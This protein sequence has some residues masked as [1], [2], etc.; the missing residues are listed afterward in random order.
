MSTPI[1]IRDNISIRK[2]LETMTHVI[3]DGADRNYYFLPYWFTQE[4]GEDE[5]ELLRL[6][7]LPIPLRKLIMEMRGEAGE[8]VWKAVFEEWLLLDDKD[9]DESRDYLRGYE[10]GLNKAKQIIK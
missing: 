3:N 7:N 5:F 4:E 10:A 2:M 8:E 1:K 6:D 9:S